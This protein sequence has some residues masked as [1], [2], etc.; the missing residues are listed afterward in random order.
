MIKIEDLG[1]LIKTR[2]H[3][4]FQDKPVPEDHW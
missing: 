1:D 4:K 3:C 2:R